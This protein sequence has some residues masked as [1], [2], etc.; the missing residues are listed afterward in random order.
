MIEPAFRWHD[1]APPNEREQR[2]GLRRACRYLRRSIGE[3]ED[4]QSTTIQ[5]E[6]T[7]AYIA[8]IGAICDAPAHVYIDRNRSGTTIRDRNGLIRMLKE[9]AHGKIDIVVCLTKCRLTRSLRDAAWLEEYFDRHGV[10]FHVVD[11]GRIRGLKMTL[12]AFESQ[13]SRKSF[14]GRSRDGNIKSAS[15]GHF[16]GS[17]ENY[18]YDRLEDRST[19]IVNKPQADVIK[20]C[21][22]ELDG[23]TTPQTLAR[24]LNLEKVPAPR[25]RLWRPNTFFNPDYGTLTRT[26][27]KGLYTFEQDGERVEI[28]MPDLR[29]L[30]DDIFDRLQE[31]YVNERRS[32][33]VDNCYGRFITASLRCICGAPM[34]MNRNSRSGVISCSTAVVGGECQPA[35]PLSSAET[36]RSIL[37]I[38]RDEIFDPERRADWNNMICHDWEMR[39]AAVDPQ[40]AE[41]T[42]ELER[43]DNAVKLTPEPV[44]DDLAP[45][46]FAVRNRLEMEQIDLAEKLDALYEPPPPNLLRADEVERLRNAC[47]RM[48][49]RLPE[50]HLRDVDED[51]KRRLREILPA[52]VLATDLKTQRYEIRMLLG[53][54]GAGTTR[55]LPEASS[56]R[57][58]VRSFPK[59]AKGALRFPDTVLAQHRRAERGEFAIS[60]HDWEGIKHLFMAS[61]RKGADARLVAEALIF[62]RLTAVPLSMLPERYYGLAEEACLRLRKVSARMMDILRSRGSNRMRTLL[63][64]FKSTSAHH[65]YAHPAP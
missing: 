5:Y 11:E 17:R 6:R 14:L 50:I 56:P 61:H 48:I 62:H 41:I 16:I 30:D 39:M 22:I 34:H 52:I 27:L 25:G 23:N 8:G 15:L 24:K 10:E 12:G 32:K 35:W 40:R 42:A 26:I 54:P 36:T 51:V 38:L 29:I 60:D 59:P 63:E 19:W 46:I 45:G 43:I 2:S 44:F 64:P 57:W 21:A 31:R 4:H 9:I 65:V 3:T 1:R 37:T 20:R 47:A 53:V 55:I 13:E 33:K 49:T 58:I 28:P 7:G 18:G